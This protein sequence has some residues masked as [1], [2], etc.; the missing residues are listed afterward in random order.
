MENAA[1]HNNKVLR[2]YLFRV[3]LLLLFAKLEL[4]CSSLAADTSFFI[5]VST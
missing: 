1:R 5:E 2:N 4:V 3:Y